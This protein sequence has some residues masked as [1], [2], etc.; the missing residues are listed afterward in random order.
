MMTALKSTLTGD[1]IAPRTRALLAG[2]CVAVVLHLSGSAVDAAGAYQL[3]Q[4]VDLS[5]YPKIEVSDLPEGYRRWLEEEVTWIITDRERDIF[6][7]LR[8]NGQRQAFVQEFWAQRD[9]TPGTPRNEYFD[10]YSERLA[11]ATDRFGRGTST[12]GWRTDRGRMYL[13]LGAPTEITRLENDQ[14]LQPTIIWRYMAETALG[15]PP[16]FYLVFYKRYGSGDY[17]LYSPLADGPKNLLNG[18]GRQAII[19]RLKGPQTPYGYGPT[20]F[21]GYEPGEISAIWEILREI[22]LDI[23]NA[24]FSLFP[25]DSGMQYIS[26]LRSE[27]LIGQIEGVPN[28]LM[29]EAKWATRVLTGVTEAEVRFESLQVQATAIALLD[30]EGIPFVHFAAQTPGR[31]LNLASYEDSYYFTFE[32]SGS[33]T[34]PE[35]RVIDLQEANVSGTLETEDQA[36]RFRSSP[37]LYVDRL[38]AIPGPITLDLVMENNVTHEFGRAEFELEVPRPHPETL[39]YSRPLLAVSIQQV[40]NYDPFGTHYPFQ[41]GE[42]ILMPSADAR[43]ILDSRIYV[44]HQFQLPE[45]YRET[46]P[47]SYVLSSEAGETMIEQEIP[48]GPAHADGLGLINQTTVLDLEG[49]PLGTYTLAIEIGGGGR[50]T[51]PVIIRN[52]DPPEVRTFVNVQEQAPVGDP[53]VALDLARQYRVVGELDA[54]IAAVEQAMSSLPNDPYASELLADLLFEADRHHDLLALLAPRLAEEPSNVQLLLRLAESSALLAEHYDAIRYYER[55]RLVSKQDTPDI[56]NPLAAEYFA[57]GNMDK[58]KELLELSL[59]LNPL[60]PEIRRM[61]DLARRQ[62]Q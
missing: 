53:Y 18:N 6:L 27:I 47:V 1:S 23:A 26:P 25:S 13:L 32:V 2:L 28:V 33:L 55:A 30:T 49:L 60:Q 51:F 7:R 24:A 50:E 11:Y 41:I 56:L 8:S 59:E 61:L 52:P 43:F 37:F 62:Q 15:V 58:A 35:H 42:W 14:L 29:P 34:D 19:D 16:Y 4:D 9:P 5:G 38:P 17:Q 54:A 57:D 10:V 20:G 39:T 21:S 46:I 40:S 12:P 44:Y 45:G 22:D 36:T 31:G 48:L 3:D